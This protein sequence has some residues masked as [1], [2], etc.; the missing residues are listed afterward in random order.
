MKE[1]IQLQAMTYDKDYSYKPTKCNILLHLQK[2][3]IY[4]VNHTLTK[5]T[6]KNSKIQNGIFKSLGSISS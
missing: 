4:Q 3:I 6:L 1:L 5:S 2:Y